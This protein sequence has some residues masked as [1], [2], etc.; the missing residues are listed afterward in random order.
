METG[1]TTVIDRIKYLIEQSRMSQAAFARRINIDPANLSKHLSGRLPVTS[2][3]VNR[4]VADLGVS[5][6]W[7]CTGA[8]LPF[9]RPEHFSV[10][11]KKPEATERCHAVPVYDLDVTAGCVELSRL[12]TD[13][14]IVG[15]L[16]LPGMGRDCA[17]VRVSGDSMTPVINNGG[18]I[19]IRKVSNPECIFW[20]QIYVI[21]LEDYRMV[22]YLRRHPSDPGMV[23]LRSANPEYDD[24]EV[25]RRDILG[26]YV[27]ESI[28]NYE[29]RC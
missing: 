5:K 22:K 10:L 11:E 17:V 25:P 20:G 15:S 21:M 29:V 19:A 12:L 8:G 2:G 6:A 9:E 18:F 7:L 14:R 23:V 28:I 16:S 4:L 1:N 27:V 13:D 26:L 24:M 3:L